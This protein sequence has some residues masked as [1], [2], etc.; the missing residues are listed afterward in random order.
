MKSFK[1]Y[2][3]EKPAKISASLPY[4]GA[5]WREFRGLE[6]PTE[7]EILA[8]M[9]KAKFSELRFTVDSKGKMWAWDSDHE[10][11]DAV[12]FGMTGQKYNGDYAKGIISF[13]DI[14]NEKAMVHRK[15]NLKV[16]VMNTRTVG[17]D[18]ALKNRTMKAIAKRINTKDA[19]KRV[20]W[21]DV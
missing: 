9:K 3:T 14:E 7:R 8:M 21:S 4:K 19:D 5:G 10:L 11:H 20:F 13:L 18:Y 2:I 1:H 12:I 17:T 6:N 15:G 16:T